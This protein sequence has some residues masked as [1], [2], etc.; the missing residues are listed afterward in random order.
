[1]ACDIFCPPPPLPMEKKQFFWDTLLGVGGGTKKYHKPLPFKHDWFWRK[2]DFFETPY[3][4]RG[5]GGTK[6]YHKP[7]PF[8]YD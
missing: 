3:W 1:M 7:L 2:N 8:K 5:G 6:K 4:V